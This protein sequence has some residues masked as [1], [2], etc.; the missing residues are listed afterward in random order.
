MKKEIKCDYCEKEKAEYKEKS[1]HSTWITYFF[2]N[3]C[4]IEHKKDMEFWNIET[5]E[6]VKL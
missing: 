6:R 4:K 5:N 1:T 3:K 2:C